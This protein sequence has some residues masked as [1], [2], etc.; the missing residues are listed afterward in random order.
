MSIEESLVVVVAIQDGLDLE[1]RV[2][3]NRSEG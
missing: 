1:H 3:D 2:A